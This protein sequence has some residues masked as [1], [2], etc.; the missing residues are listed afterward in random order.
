VARLAEGL[1]GDADGADVRQT[2]DVREGDDA[3]PNNGSNG[4]NT[5]VNVSRET[6][7]ARVAA[8]RAARA[9]DELEAGVGALLRRDAVALA[10]V[11]GRD[12]VDPA[13]DDA[14]RAAALAVAEAL[15]TAVAASGSAAGERA[16]EHSLRASGFAFGDEET[17]GEGLPTFPNF[18][19]ADE[20]RAPPGGDLSRLPRVAGGNSAAAAGLT[21][22][23]SIAPPL[24]ADP[25]TSA[26]ARALARAGVIRHCLAAVQ[27]ANLSD[28]ILPTAAAAARL[29]ATR[30]ALGV[31]LRLAQLPGG[32]K[33]LCES[34]AMAALAACR[35]V[36]AYAHDSPGD[37]AAAAAA[38]AARARAPRRGARRVAAARSGDVWAT[39]TT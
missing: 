9:Q 20:N 8:R 3:P 10:D 31:L 33:A 16:A 11:V 13:V 14:T 24:V 34:G 6:R 32:A 1:V 17:S 38:A 23:R 39:A 36:D 19:F 35:A 12:I 28:V 18:A 22:T 25:A 21:P 27:S 4:S 26:L 7:D 37:A 5:S 2:A 30:A 15:L 29:A